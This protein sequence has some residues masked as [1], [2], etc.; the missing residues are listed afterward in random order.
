MITPMEVHVQGVFTRKI[1]EVADEL[2]GRS[3]SPQLVSKLAKGLDV[4]VDARRNRRL[5]G[6]YPYLVDAH[7]EGARENG[8]IASGG[9]LIVI[10]IDSEGHRVILA[11]AI[12]DRDTTTCSNPLRDLKV[13]GATG[14]LLIATFRK[15]A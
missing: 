14:V 2:A 5:D 4:K 1:A 3:F 6:E 11:V 12:A 10:G 13:S 9:V 7:R 15:R 8:G